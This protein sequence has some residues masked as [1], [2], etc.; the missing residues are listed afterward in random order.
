[1]QKKIFNKL[2]WILLVLALVIINFLGSIIHTKIDLTKEKRYTINKATSNILQKLEDKV[3]V[4][5]F[6]NGDLP[7]GFKKLANTTEDFL[8]LLKENNSS[9]I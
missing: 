5:V 2:S 4:I 1:M 7:S 9:K 6:L 8:R 3:E